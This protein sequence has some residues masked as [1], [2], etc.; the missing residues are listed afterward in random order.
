MKRFQTGYD[1]FVQYPRDEHGWRECGK[2]THREHSELDG[3]T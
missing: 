3:E 2:S 1:D